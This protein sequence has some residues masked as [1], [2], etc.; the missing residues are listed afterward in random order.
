MTNL[1]SSGIKG[2]LGRHTLEIILLVMII[3]C[4][5]FAPGFTRIG[6][7]LGIL[8]AVT[9]TGVIAFGMTM[10][11]I[12]GE[13]DLSVGSSVA[14]SSVLVAWTTGFL[15]TQF[16]IYMSGGVIIGMIVALTVGTAIGFLNGF[17]RTRFNMP[18]FIITLAMLNVLFGLAA[19]ISRGFPLTTLPRWYNFIGA[20][21][22]AGYIP[23]PAVILLVVFA[24]VF[25]IMNYTRFGRE[26]Y[27]VGGNPEAARLSGINVKKVKI[28]A[29][30]SVQ[31]LAALSGIIL[32]AQVQAGSSQF[33]RGYELDV[34]AAVI[35]G[36]TSLSGGIGKVRGT[37][38]GILFLGV[39]M[40]AMTLFGIDSFVQNVVRGLLILGAVLLYTIQNERMKK[41]KKL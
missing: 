26:V 10:V 27:A 14:L 32:S 5:L 2:F 13:I 36:G 40:N 37:L 41:A 9:L 19:I 23:V 34:I 3:F 24:I 22:I 31:F 15:S 7:L 8:R 39:I 29:M 21:T 4:F 18:S 12:S 30:M 28:L 38:V 20:G 35:V 25:T 1:N 6:N 17:I 33:G 11:I 16:G